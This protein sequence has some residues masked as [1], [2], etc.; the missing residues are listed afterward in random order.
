MKK[1]YTT[2]LRRAILLLSVIFLSQFSFAQQDYSQKN[3][4]STFVNY[5]QPYQEVMYAH[6]NKTKFIMGES[7]G[8]TVYAFNKKTKLLSSVT[9]NIYA[10][11]TDENNKVVKEQM[12]KAEN[13]IANG[14]FSIDK[15]FKEGAYNIKVFTNWMMNFSGQNIFEE[16]FEII[17]TNSS[18]SK[19]KISQSSNL[20]VQFL[21]E[22][23]HLLENVINTVGVIAKDELGF[24][25]SDLKGEVFNSKNNKITDFSLSELGVGRF[26]LTPKIGESY[27]AIINNNGKKQQVSL[28]NTIEKKG[29]ILKL[30]RNNN[31]VIVSIITNENS[32]NIVKNKDYKLSFH[33]G[34]NINSIP[35][36][37]KGQLVQ[38]AKIP[39]QKLSKGINI[40]TLFNDKNEPIAERLFFNYMKLSFN[41]SKLLSKTTKNGKTNI[42]L[43]FDASEYLGFNNVS[44]SILPIGTKSYTKHDNM[45]SK[46]LLKPY[47]KGFV[48]NA[49]YYFTDINEKKKHEL[50]NLLITQGWSSYDWSKMFNHQNQYNYTFDEGISIKV[51]L[52]KIE[53]KSKYLIHT[54]NSK[55]PQLI[56]FEDEI[57][58]FTAYKYY[59]EKEDNLFISKVGKNGDLNKVPVYVQFSPSAIPN[60]SNKV[61]FLK[62]KPSYY[63]FENFVDIDKFMKINNRETLDEVVIKTNL[64]KKRKKDILS[65]SMGRV[66]FLRDF[67]RIRMLAEY[68]D[69]QAGISARDNYQTSRLEIINRTAGGVPTMI[70]NGIFIYDLGDLF[71]YSMNLVD[72]VE[73]NSLGISL[74]PGGKGGT[75]RI[76]ED[77]KK[78][79]IQRETVTKIEFPL[80]YSKTKKFYVPEYAS[81]NNKFFKNYGVIDW[82][83]VNKINENGNLNLG[84]SNNKAKEVILFIEG[85]TEDGTYIMEEKTMKL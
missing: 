29:V 74:Q 63:T 17:S 62:T 73:I 83:P 59:P 52:S 24:G 43:Q 5:A 48:E 36:N 18:Q 22:S 4:D 42:N 10:V 54:V 61:S 85:I 53:E 37:F 7:I 49:N 33:N 1:D 38:T 28:T 9:S 34:K 11:I 21:P 76:V 65:N 68:L 70:L 41:K 84:F 69:F 6:L 25:V 39:L 44:V 2:S 19:N 26:S 79:Y 72:Y 3:I 31:S 55:E 12:I 82:L 16:K 30:S 81:Y 47:V 32:K 75:I 8:Y 20:D 64:E 80:S 15:K 50:D 13:G 71:L 40:F 77:P 14:E 56:S 45:I 67:D 66:K 60:V 58:S 27:Y 78:F 51:N 57:K 46:T 35:V 23:G